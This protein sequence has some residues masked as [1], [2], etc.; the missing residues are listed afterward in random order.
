MMLDAAELEEIAAE[1]QRPQSLSGAHALW[2][3]VAALGAAE[4]ALLAA[5][6]GWIRT[7]ELA[8]PD[9]ADKAVREAA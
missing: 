7:G 2:N 5:R 9:V 4:A 3:R 8:R 1:L 6:L